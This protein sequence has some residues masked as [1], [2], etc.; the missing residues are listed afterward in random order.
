MS[1]LTKVFTEHKKTATI[2][3]VAVAVIL[4][5]GVGIACKGYI[6]NQNRIKQQAKESQE[7]READKIAKQKAD[8]ESQ[9]KALAEA[10]TAKS[11]SPATPEA[12]A[13]P[14]PVA[15]PVATTKPQTTPESKPKTK[16]KPADNGVVTSISLSG[17]GGASVQWSTAGYS[18]KGFKVVWSKVSGPTYPT[19]STDKYQYLSDPASSAT[20]LS[21]FDGPGTYFVRVCEYLGGACGVYSNQ[22]TVSL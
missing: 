15:K 6:D 7:Q 10:E 4:S 11:A 5:T 9:K 14:A 13:T 2:G 8:E 19:R 20:S 18:D 1:I 16:P 21:A 3:L 17:I 22:I 12:T